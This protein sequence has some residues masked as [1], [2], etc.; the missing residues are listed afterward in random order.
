MM[1]L[2]L[3]SFAGAAIGVQIGRLLQ[4]YIDNVTKRNGD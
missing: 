4:I 2:L 3:G 1:M